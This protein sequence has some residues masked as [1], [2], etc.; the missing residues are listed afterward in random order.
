MNISQA[1]FNAAQSD[2]FYLPMAEGEARIINMNW[3]SVIQNGGIEST[4][5]SCADRGISVDGGVVSGPAGK[6]TVIN[7]ITTDQGETLK[8][9]IIITIAPVDKPLPDYA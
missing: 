3:N 8:R 7:T 4:D 9:K 6:Y 1:N 2:T 5:W